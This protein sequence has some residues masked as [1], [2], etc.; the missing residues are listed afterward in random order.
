[1]RFA[2]LKPS[3]ETLNGNEPRARRGQEH[4]IVLVLVVVLVLDSML[5]AREHRE[6]S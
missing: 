4:S 1:M 6:R 2:K 3:D 5:I